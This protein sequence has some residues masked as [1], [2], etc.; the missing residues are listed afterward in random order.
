MFS[1]KLTFALILYST[2]TP[3]I[4]TSFLSKN[5]E[6]TFVLYNVN[7]PSKYDLSSLWLYK[8]P[9]NYQAEKAISYSSLRPKIIASLREKCPGET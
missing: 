8:F 4:K 2:T 6:R 1:N 5:V 7:V 9:Q 3:E